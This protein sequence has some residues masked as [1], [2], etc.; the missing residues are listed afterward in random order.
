MQLNVTLLLLVSLNVFFS[1]N[2]ASN[3]QRNMS[4]KTSRGGNGV[5]K[6]NPDALLKDFMSWYNYAYYNVRLEQEFIGNDEDSKEIDKLKFLQELSSGNYVAFRVA[7]KD[8]VPVYKLYLPER[9]DAGIKTTVVQMAQA[10][11]TLAAMEG[12]ELPDYH[13]VDLQGNS[14]DKK[15]TKGQLM[16]VKCW[17]INCT[18]CVKEFPALNQLVDRY[19][20]RTDIKFISLASDS[21]SELVTFLQKKPFSFAVVPKMGKYMTDSLQVNAYPLHLLV[22]KQGKVIKATNYIE[23]MIPFFEKEAR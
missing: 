1:C 8:S 10:A 12:K 9:L 15:N 21:K 13:L 3:D 19:K 18:A 22:N 23:D 20:S 7:L 2:N 16:L 5:Y 4:S 11:I 17:F 14:Y 6:V